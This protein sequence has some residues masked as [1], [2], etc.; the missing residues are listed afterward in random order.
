MVH[1]P[2]AIPAGITT[3]VPTTPPRITKKISSRRC[4]MG[5]SPSAVLYTAES[6]SAREP[7]PSHGGSESDD[8]HPNG[9]TVPPPPLLPTTPPRT[10]KTSSRRNKTSHSP[11][12]A[13]SL[14]QALLSSDPMIGWDQ[15]HTVDERASIALSM[16]SGSGETDPRS[17][18][19]S[20]LRDSLKDAKVMKA[21]T[22]DLSNV[23]EGISTSKSTSASTSASAS[24]SEKD[25]S[26]ASTR[27]QASVNL[28]RS[29]LAAISPEA[30]HDADLIPQTLP[31]RS[32][33]SKS[34]SASG[35]SSR[36]S[37]RQK[38]A[39]AKTPPQSHSYQ[40]Q[41]PF[42][43]A[44]RKDSTTSQYSTD[45]TDDDP[46]RALEDAAKEIAKR[47][48]RYQSA[49]DGQKIAGGGRNGHGTFSDAD[50]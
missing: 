16:L 5:Y 9:N 10:Q 35:G 23:D 29:A 44:H 13:P 30:I 3:T 24:A 17:S 42:A 4:K 12:A 49:K 6:P 26:N 25:S 21:Y 34:T 15:A 22:R 48:G 46:L 7:T 33:T 41:H 14:R 19:T 11:S 45:T 38:L 40:Y 31:R 2:I 47:T 8:V 1:I 27:V 39:P 43:F 18:M 37:R 36:S 20:S 32:P 28:Y 50:E